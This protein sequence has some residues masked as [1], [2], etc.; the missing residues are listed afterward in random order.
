MYNKEQ[1]I[2][3]STLSESNLASELQLCKFI[4]K[5]EDGKMSQ[6]KITLINNEVDNIFN[7]EPNINQI[8]ETYIGKI[9]KTRSFNLKP[10]FLELIYNLV[11]KRWSEQSNK[12]TLE[13]LD[14]WEDGIMRHGFYK[15]FNLTKSDI[16]QLIKYIKKHPQYIEDNSY[17]IYYSRKKFTD[18]CKKEFDIKQTEE[19]IIEKLDSYNDGSYTQLPYSI[20]T[21]V[22]YCIQ[23][24]WFDLWLEIYEILS[25]APLQGRIIYDIKT[26]EQLLM[27]VEAEKKQNIKH[28]KVFAFLLRNMAFE[29]FINQHDLLERNA[30][31]EQLNKSQIKQVKKALQ[32]WIEHK[33][34]YLQKFVNEFLSV[35]FEKDEILRWLSEK[36]RIA[37]SKSGVYKESEIILI[38]KIWEIIQ[39]KSIQ[40]IEVNSTDIQTLFSYIYHIDCN[41]LTHKQCAKIIKK[42]CELIYTTENLYINWNFSDESFKQMRAVNSYIKYSETDSIILAKKYLLENEGYK[43]TIPQHLMLHRANK[44]WLSAMMLQVEDS[45]APE[46]DF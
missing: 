1:Y 37:S 10:L 2:L 43:T 40:L 9:F 45:E 25:Y 8:N 41:K 28:R 19:D 18:Y 23:N 21:I 35:F 7:N 30:E 6:Q 22:H 39:S 20:D 16:E 14:K 31:N 46:V 32:Y 34:E 4:K 12:V 24:E 44:I 38:N 17:D 33:D 26:V 27:V 13:K 15:G 11:G 5:Y 36:E 3:Y 42:M 29:L